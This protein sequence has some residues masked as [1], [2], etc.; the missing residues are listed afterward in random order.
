[1]ATEV[2]IPMLGVT[3]ENGKIIEW[4]KSEGDSVEKGESI[5]V[6]EADKV[7]TEVESPAS[8]VLAKIL[9]PAGREA[10][11]LTVAGI[12]TAPGEAVP[13]EYLEAS[14]AVSEA[15]SSEGQPEAPPESEPVL[16]LPTAGPVKVVP[17]ARR[18]ARE[19]NLDLQS[20]TPTGPDGVI[21][22]RDVVNAVAKREEAPTQRV[23]TLA[24]RRAEAAGVSLEGVEGSGVRGRIMRADVEAALSRES[25]AGTDDTSVFGTAI[26]MTGMRRAIARRLGQ[27]AASAPHVAFYTDIRMDRLLSF[28][29]RIVDD[30]ETHCGLRPSVND[31]LIK[32]I[33]LTIREFP[34]MN[35]FLEGDDIHIAPC[36]NVGLAVAVPD[37]LVVPAV[38]DA[39]RI[40]LAEIVRQRSD[41]VVRAR[42]GRLVPEEM[43]RGTFT[44]SSLAGRDITFFTSILNPPQSGILS[45]PKTREELALKD[46][47][48]MVRRVASMGLT[49]D[50]RII[51]GAVAADF[52]ESFKRKLESPEFAFLHV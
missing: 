49:V 39:D 38:T 14:E 33:G 46:G 45:V 13:T 20:V 29:K 48:V 16:E 43:E 34:L 32:A 31:F 26:P 18:L 42:A 3:V 23:S 41:L 8:G 40:G 37:G 6:V 21:T 12:I 52:L 1:M 5:F 30:F 17:A 25:A 28:R 11:V 15:P 2:V 10:P 22:H 19:K 27:S 9:L 4:L 36:I 24:R 47:E 51:D 35:G 50:H 7:T 44:I